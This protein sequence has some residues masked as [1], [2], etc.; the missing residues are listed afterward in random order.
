MSFSCSFEVSSGISFQHL[1]TNLPHKGLF[2]GFNQ[3]PL[4][5]S[6]AVWQNIALVSYLV[7]RWTSILVDTNDVSAHRQVRSA[8]HPCIPHDDTAPAHLPKPV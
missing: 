5:W 4:Q 1:P 8:M 7:Q 2:S 3:H 6:A